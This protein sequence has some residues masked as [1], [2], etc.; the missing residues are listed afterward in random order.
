[1]S[2]SVDGG[3]AWGRV[4]VTEGDLLPGKACG[5]SAAI[6]GCEATAVDL[7]PGSI[8]SRRLPIAATTVT[9]IGM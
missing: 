2:L 9:A 7:D 5:S 1:M 6:A 8:D 4:V 3:S